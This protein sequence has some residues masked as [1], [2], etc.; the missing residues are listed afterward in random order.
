MDLSNDTSRDKRVELIL[1][2]L[3]AVPPLPGIASLFARSAACGV[4]DAVASLN[5]NPEFA[6]RVIKLSSAIDNAGPHAAETIDSLFKKHG[7]E[8]LRY[9]VLAVGAY[10]TFAA[11]TNNPEH[12]RHAVAVGCAAE[13][14]AEQM[15]GTWGKDSQVEPFEAFACGFLHDL[16]KMVLETVLPK[17]FARAVEAAEMLRGNIADIERSVIGIDHMVAGKRLAERWEL[18]AALRDCI[19]LHGQAPQALPATV[20][21]PRLVNLITLADLLAREQHI[22][23]S[24]NYVY[25]VTRQHLLDAVGVTPEQV[26]ATLESLVE[27]IEQHAEALGIGE[28]TTGQLY[29]HAITQA[30]KELDRVQTE[31]ATKTKRLQIRGK[32]FEAL[33]GFQGEIRP[34]APPQTILRAIGQT[35]VTL[36]D[37]TSAGAFSLIP[38]QEFAEVLLFDNN[39]EVFETSLVDCPQRPATPAVGVGPVVPAGAE[40]EWLLAAISP[41]LAHDQRFWIALE[42][43]GQ[44]IGGVVWGALPGESARLGP[45]VQEITA[46]A[47]GWSLALRTA[48]IREE[49]KTLSEQL[50]EVNRKLQ[51][52][53]SEILRSRTM[54]TVGEMAAGAAHEMNNPL[55]VI[56][57]RSQLLSQQLSDPKQKAAAHLIHEQAHRLTDII[58]ELMDFAKPVPPQIADCDLSDL[59]DRALHEA[60]MQADVVDRTVEVTIGDVPAVVVDKDQVMSALM[61][62]FDNSFNATDP[63]KGHITVNAAFDPFSRKVAVTISDNGCG[64]D[65]TTLKRAFDP[66]FSMRPAG[67]RRGMGL[68]K[69]LRWVE[70][71]GGSIRLESRPGQGTRSLILL[72]AAQ[73]SAQQAKKAPRKAAQ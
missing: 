51:S 13:L 64:M 63:V 9:S 21:R 48:Q 72:P 23:Y 39:G 42:A 32:F 37:V 69:A 5:A 65:A 59:I 31:L 40:L 30:N 67:R 24:G 61:E 41:R 18:P 26:D 16:G 22:G 57:G 10:H 20:S 54:I 43:D 14:L 44:C 52:A 73:P 55:A 36:L 27:R 12:W 2:Q 11:T 46:I 4:A 8:P 68:P 29:Q 7:I 33:A 34:D 28:A 60:K 17:S 3:E 56:S 15:V 6:E 62:L 1:Q 50:A 45:Q 66:F 19:W 38:G 25:T 49:A 58:T 47:S 70:A 71:S 53:Q 35:A